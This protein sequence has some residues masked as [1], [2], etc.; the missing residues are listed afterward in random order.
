MTYQVS[1]SYPQ[2]PNDQ[3]RKRVEDAELPCAKRIRLLERLD[4][5]VEIPRNEAFL[6]GLHATKKHEA[7]ILEEMEIE[8]PEEE[9]DL[10]GIELKRHQQ[11]EVDDISKRKDENI[12]TQLF[13]LFQILEGRRVVNKPAGKAI[14][15]LAR[16][17][18]DQVPDKVARGVSASEEYRSVVEKNRDKLPFDITDKMVDELALE[19][20]KAFEGLKNGS[21]EEMED[22][23]DPVGLAQM[24]L[25]Y[26]LLASQHDLSLLAEGIDAERFTESLDWASKRVSD[27]LEA[28]AKRIEDHKN[29]HRKTAVQC[30]K[31]AMFLKMSLEMADILL[32]DTGCINFGV[33]EAAAEVLIPDSLK[34]TV[35]VENLW[36]VLED[37][38]KS[39]VLRQVIEKV[40][41]PESKK[42]PS[43]AAIR[44]CFGLESDQTITRRHAQLLVLSALIGHLRQAM[45]GTCFATACLIKSRLSFPQL[46]LVDLGELTEKGYV[47]RMLIKEPRKFPFQA[48]VTKEFL[49]VELSADEEGRILSAARY[50]AAPD[51]ARKQ[52]QQGAYLHE[53]PGV[54][55]ACRSIGLKNVRGAVMNALQDLPE[56]FSVNDL[57]AVLA[58][59]AYAVQQ[60]A[61]YH[62][63]SM[64]KLSYDDLLYRAEFAYGCQTNHPLHQG[65]EQAATAMVNYFG[66]QYVMPAW[67]YW[68]MDEVLE[69]ADKG[70]PRAFQMKYKKLMREMFLP[71]ITRMRYVYNPN[72]GKVKSLFNDGNYGRSEDRFYGYQLCDTGLPKDFKYSTNLYHQYKSEA[73]GISLEPFDDYPPPHQWKLVD[74]KDKF[75]D[76]LKRVAS[77]T[78]KYLKKVSRSASE[79]KEWD[80]VLSKIEK[81]F[82]KP[83]FIKNMIFLLFERGSDQKKNFKKDGFNIR[84]MPWQFA[85]GGDFNEVLKTYFG[86]CKSPSRLKEYNGSPREVLAKCINF[87]KKQPD[88]I[89]ESYE[90][91]RGQIIVTSSVHVF[92]MRPFEPTFRDAWESDIS[93]N[94]YIREHVEKPGLAVAGETLPAEQRRQL[95]SYVADNMWVSRYIEKV[96]WVR[97]QLTEESKAVFDQEL[98][99]SPEVFDMS[100]FDF[101][102]RVAKIVFKSRAAD[103]KIGERNRVWEDRFQRVFNNF[104]IRLVPD[105]ADGINKISRSTAEKLIDFARNRKDTMALGPAAVR[106]FKNLMRRVPRGASVSEFRKALVSAAYRAKCEEIGGEDPK[107]KEKFCEYLDSKLFAIL[108]DEAKERLVRSGI[109]THDTNWKKGIH[110]IHFIFLVNPGTA[111]IELARYSPDT[112]KVKFMDQKDW[113][114]QGGK[115]AN[116]QFPDNYR[117]WSG[118]PLFNVKEHIDAFS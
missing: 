37:L 108:P 34:E 51:K 15:Q 96:D 44:A 36:I 113:F 95:I 104:A 32:L 75:R 80:L 24:R 68:T 38:G 63:R 5:V 25:G 53:S 110:D 99:R 26:L 1:G 40:K 94:D 87:I 114:P 66:A 57:L 71:M 62:L 70:F 56:K 116:W 42:V 18:I 3:K 74:D 115:H 47:T 21:D 90:V 31:E 97:Q 11:R 13:E 83:S 65:Y 4:P 49:D 6:W 112:K 17:I 10:C 58:G 50:A 102:E 22:G 72:F 78:V 9:V 52:P 111:E 76:F 7:K 12:G 85:W 14:L 88:E 20:Q 43:D 48:R 28:A 89:K 105:S 16:E 82:E 100:L 33:I 92:L 103:K 35:A 109:V 29:A 55:A 84:S 23:E 91:P 73:R 98:Q 2:L 77:D 118:A 69:K 117:V 79:R 61:S 81:D 93:A 67:V 45:A 30:E 19:M 54:I 60:S 106:R 101:T 64:E 46:F 39:A 86:F 27:I 8:V 41:P 107:W 59:H